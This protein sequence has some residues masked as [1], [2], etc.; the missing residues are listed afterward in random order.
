[1]R[2]I[3]G[4]QRGGISKRTGGVS[5][6]VFAAI[7]LAGQVDPAAAQGM[8]TGGLQNA[9]VEIAY[10]QPSNRNYVPIYTPFTSSPENPQ[11]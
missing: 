3:T 10:V 2:T 9:Q 5:A 8:A 6:A 4:S 11:G 7:L 1:M